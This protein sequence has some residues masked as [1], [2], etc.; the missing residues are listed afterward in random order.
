MMQIGTFAAREA[1]HFLQF[2]E[3]GLCQAQIIQADGKTQ[4]PQQRKKLAVRLACK[5][6][7]AQT[8]LQPKLHQD[9]EA[10]LLTMENVVT[11]LQLG[12]S[13]V[14]GM[15]CDR[16]AAGTP[17]PPITPAVSA[18]AS[19]VRTQAALAG[20]SSAFGLSINS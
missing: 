15:G 13:V 11:G 7:A 17:K 18:Q 20:S 8:F 6:V 14:N 19:A 2:T 4:L 9:S 1:A 5:P 16:A 3:T 10:D 12:E